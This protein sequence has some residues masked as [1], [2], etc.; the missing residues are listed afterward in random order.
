VRSDA[1]A[2]RV[3]KLF[4][5][6][7]IFFSDFFAS[8]SIPHP[9]IMYPSIQPFIRPTML[10]ARHPPA[11]ALFI[12]KFSSSLESSFYVFFFLPPLFS[13]HSNENHLNIIVIF[14]L[15][16]SEPTKSLL[17]LSPVLTPRARSNSDLFLAAAAADADA[18]T[19]P[20][21]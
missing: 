15:L 21:T 11:P 7:I 6:S 16:A 9:M 3:G 17:P 18:T 19:T 4:L 2:A 5:D 8:R 12:F 14:F 10:D 20:T 13:F 1:A